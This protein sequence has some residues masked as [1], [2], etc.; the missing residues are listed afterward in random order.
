MSIISRAEVAIGQAL[1]V[2]RVRV[3]PLFLALMVGASFAGMLKTA[4][5]LFLFVLLH[6]FGH[7]VTARALGYEVEEVSLLPFGGVAKV[8]YA[9][10]GF[11]P[12]EEAMVAIAGPFVNLLLCIACSL[13]S[14]VRVIDGDTYQLCMQMNSWIGI[15]NLLPGLPLDGG[16]ILRAARSRQIG[17]ERATL[18]A[19]NVALALAILLMLT[20]VLALFTGH[21]HLG[22]M[23]LGLFLFATAWR[24]KKDVRSETMRFLDAKRQQPKAV[25]PMYT[26]AV[27]HSA[28]I[29]DVVVQF[30][31]DRYHIV[32]ILGNDGLVQALLE[33][34]E[35]LDAVFEGRWLEP[36]SSL[37]LDA[38]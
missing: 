38:K 25:L 13:L 14:A 18:E 2:G 31:P 20:G 28:P 3:H 4:V 29:R 6:E 17:Y 19:Y 5:L 9:R 32:Y 27:L 16:R 37:L 11:S 35:I 12:R 22:M 23:L 30:A 24:G 21:P 34:I 26:L 1:G 33:E 15:F 36:M 8:S 7:A 10:L